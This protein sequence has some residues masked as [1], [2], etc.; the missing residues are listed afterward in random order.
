MRRLL[1]WV[2]GIV[3]AL[4]VI[5]FAGAYLLP[6]V[7]A[8]QRQTE[9]AAP[10]AKVFALIAAIRRFNEFSPWIE[11][12]PRSK[13]AF[14]GP[15]T[16]TGQKMSWQSDKLGQGSMMIT[17]ITPDRRVGYELD[18]G[19]MGKATASLELAPVGS[20]TAVTW[21]FRQ[22]LT[23]PLQRWF[24]L[25]IGNWVGSDYERGLAKLKA[26]AEKEAAAPAQ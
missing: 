7:T 26:L 21:G 11:M 22:A 16:G 18:F 4:I 12:D 1:K 6:G 19:D 15:E 25:M 8:V 20:G 5:F 10:P 17:D 9:I 13:I 3:A 14:E 23:N 24:G 2:A